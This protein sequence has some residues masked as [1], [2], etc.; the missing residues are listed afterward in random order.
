MLPFVGVPVVLEITERASL[1][2]VGNI[3]ARITDLKK[4]GFSIAVDDLGAGYAGL[5][6]FSLLEPHVVKLDMSLIRDLHLDDTKKK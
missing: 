4:L 5:S 2:N 1:D 3:R 6:S